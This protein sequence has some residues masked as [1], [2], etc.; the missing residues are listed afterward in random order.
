MRSPGHPWAWGAGG[1]GQG[2]PRAS[3][4]VGGQRAG[5]PSLLQVPGVGQARGGETGLRPPCEVGTSTCLGLA[6]AGLACSRRPSEAGTFAGTWLCQE[7]NLCLPA[8]IPSL[9]LHTASPKPWRRGTVPGRAAQH[10]WG[11]RAGQGNCLCRGAS[12]RPRA[13]PGGCRQIGATSVSP[14]RPAPPHLCG[15]GAYGDKAQHRGLGTRSVGVAEN[16][17]GGETLHLTRGS[18][19]GLLCLW[20]C[21]W[22]RGW[23]AWA[24]LVAQWPSVC[25]DQSALCLAPGTQ[26]ALPLPPWPAPPIGGQM[27][28]ELSR[29]VGGEG[30][31]GRE[32]VL[33]LIEKK[34]QIL[35]S[36]PEAPLPP[37]CELFL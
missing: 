1:C 6:P 34:L 35:F 16:S 14:D 25:G 7:P 30:W 4:A 26:W 3:A 20:V 31:P 5:G 32:Q 24:A 2:W 23:G 33:V 9:G 37:P 28:P 22:A 21:L 18:T 19:W 36:K 29:P 11:R 10:G 17:L 27:V 12:A 13:R 8:A 15:T